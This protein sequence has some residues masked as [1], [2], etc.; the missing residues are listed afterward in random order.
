MPQSICRPWSP[1]RR[2]MI[3][4]LI[5]AL[6]RLA[7]GATATIDSNATNQF[8]RGFGASSAWCN[9]S[10][11]A[12][13]AAE[14]WADDSVD[15]HAG[16]SILR[17]R[18]D[19]TGSF[20]SEAANMT[21]AKAQ[22]PNLC[23][24]STE[25][26]PPAAYKNN[27]SVNGPGANNTFN[28]TATNSTAYAN[29]LVGY[30]NTIKSSYGVDL[31]AVSPQNEP[32]WNTSY[33]SCLWSAAQFDDFVK[34]YLYPA[35]QG[36][37]LST[38]IMIPESFADNL[39]MAATTMDDA[40]AAPMVSIIGNHLYGGG[41]NPLSSGG[42]SHLSNQE[43]WETE[44]SDVNGATH[45][46]S[47]TPALQIANWVQSCMVTGSMNA[48]LHWWIY[49]Y[50]G[51]DS[52]LFGTSTTTPTKKLYA[53]G[54]FSKF[55]R[56]GFYRMG[57][58]INP[59][60]TGVSVSAYKDNAGVPGKFVIVAINTTASPVNQ[61]FSL[62]NF[63]ALS[64]TP[65]V[66][67]SSFD[68]AHQAAVAVSGGGFSY[69]LPAQSVVSFV[70]FCTGA[71]SPTPTV[72]PTLTATL[73]VTPT[74]TGSP[75]RTRSSTPSLT[76][77]ALPTATRT[78]TPPSSQTFTPSSTRTNT[79]QPTVSDT[80]SLS[81]TRTSS[82]TPTFS[83]SFSSTPSDTITSTPDSSPTPPLSSTRTPLQTQSAT[84][85]PTP[86]AS[87]TPS[88]PASPLPSASPSPSFSATGTVQTTAS[89]SPQSTASATALPSASQ[90]AA[91]LPSSTQASTA[92]PT[93][94]DTATTSPS[95]TSTVTT[96][97]VPSLQ[98][99][100]SRT[101][102]SVPSPSATD[103]P[104]PSVTVASSWTVTPSRT[105]SPSAMPSFSPTRPETGTPTSTRTPT[106][107]STETTAPNGVLSKVTQV[108][109]AKGA[110]TILPNP[111]R[112]AVVTLYP[113][114][115]YGS[116][117]IKVQIFSVAYRLVGEFEFPSMRW[118]P[119][120]IPLQA[121]WGGHLPQGL[122]YVVLKTDKLSAVAKMLVL[123]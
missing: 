93:P 117:D 5:L 49:S 47:M 19:P 98:A 121:H 89:V 59:G 45:D 82:L 105:F 43:S 107:M 31:Y 64:V 58:T 84:A 60:S 1:H 61:G 2:A 100:P 76:Q 10:T 53:L 4:L 41:P 97:P 63:T 3:A 9:S 108:P 32:D 71:A 52:G 69:T 21:L 46:P 78:A 95:M 16:L 102:T 7:P 29:Y 110:L 30:I 74:L 55:I 106:S 79:L 22:N 28:N 40:T 36:G 37:G 123:E 66:T 25:W 119:I 44:M 20:A 72:T 14:L 86:Q 75:T 35:L 91:A 57:G 48:Y 54:Q 80:P 24:W 12:P 26:T 120:Q 67:D 15:G 11:L 115:Y 88:L 34:N 65:W 122:Y 112:A 83:P 73:T 114:D 94:L 96:S 101:A 118:Q 116:S 90:T 109:P 70:G 42:F 85:L 113:P 68:L 33:E 81:L 50:S 39:A 17:T 104:Q 62:S 87:P 99:S 27:N 13:A 77:T 38:K 111:V 23:I 51:D 8:I 56:P 6:P 103:S 92:A 18:I